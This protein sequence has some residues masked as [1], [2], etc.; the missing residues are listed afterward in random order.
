[1]HYVVESKPN[2][3]HTRDILKVSFQTTLRLKFRLSNYCF[4]V[5]IETLWR[6][7]QMKLMANTK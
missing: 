7:L 3:F 2:L 4:K 5:S 1:M 6:K